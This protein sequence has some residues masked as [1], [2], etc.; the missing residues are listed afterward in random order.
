MGALLGCVTGTPCQYLYVFLPQLIRL[1]VGKSYS[2]FRGGS[3]V[4]R[5]EEWRSGSRKKEE[6]SGRR[7]PASNTYK[8]A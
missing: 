1:S 5:G 4:V 8:I 3:R 7:S 6:G 2:L